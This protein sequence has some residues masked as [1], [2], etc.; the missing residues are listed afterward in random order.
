[1]RRL[2]LVVLPAFGLASGCF[3]APLPLPGDPEPERP[4]VNLNGAVPPVYQVLNVSYADT[5][6]PFT[7]PFTSVDAG[8]SI[9][10]YLWA[11]W[12][13]EGGF[14]ITKNELPPRPPQVDSGMGGS[15]SIERELQFIWRGPTG[16]AEGCNQLTLFI[17]HSGNDGFPADLPKD[18]SKA[19]MVTWWVNVNASL[20]QQQTLVNCPAPVLGP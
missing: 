14:N 17:T 4:N 11:N 10:W 3:F 13:L 8:Q 2:A 15:T 9:Y 12:N 5:A 1:M 16:L 7:I 6:V 19:A 20:D 18:L